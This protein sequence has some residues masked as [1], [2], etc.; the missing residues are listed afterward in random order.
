MRKRIEEHFNFARLKSKYRQA[1]RKK[2]GQLLD[3]VGDIT[4]IHRKSL[5]RML[6]RDSHRK[7]KRRGLKPKYEYQE[8]LPI[9]KNIWFA[10]DQLCSK[11][12]HAAIPD[13]LPFY[14]KEQGMLS[15]YIRLQMLSISPSTIDRLL[16]KIKVKTGRKGLG[17]TKPGSLLKNQIPIK[18]NQ[19]NEQQAGFLEAD[20]VAHCG[21]SL[22]GNFAWS[23]T[24]TDI[25]TAWTENRAVWNKGATGVVSQIRDVEANLPFKIRGFDCD[26]GSE[27]LNWHLVRYFAD[28]SAG[29]R[30]QFTRSRP[31]HKNDNAHVE[32]KNWTHV[33]QSFGYDRFGD[34]RVIPLMNDFYK[35]EWSL[36]QN[37]FI[38]TMK[39]I[40][41]ER[42]NSKYRKKF[43]LPQTP[44]ARVL[45]CPEIDQ[46]I[47]DRLKV[48]HAQLN[49]YALKKAIQQKLNE[50]FKYVVVNKNP[51][52]KI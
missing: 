40:K 33:R 52:T 37:H 47:K 36:Y 44:Y 24:F 7:K 48:Q 28:R 22:D 38:P 6:N 46:S 42:I 14:E 1:S 27:F 17:G 3:E 30:V 15:D 5:I 26:N 2:R 41:K 4:G 49:P 20:T 51:R 39:C 16:K 29:E 35:N 10:G 50:I 8:V 12:L 45:A 31:Y 25:H 32:Q 13:W 23:I 19:W 21:N 34:S 9:L 11:K 43:D 18:V